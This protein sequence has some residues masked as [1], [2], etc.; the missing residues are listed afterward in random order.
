MYFNKPKKRLGS[1][2]ED[3]LHIKKH[4]FFNDIDW[5][6]LAK[7]ELVPP[8]IPDVKNPNDIKYISPEFTEEEVNQDTY[9]DRFLK[10]RI[11]NYEGFSFVPN[12]LKSNHSPLGNN[13]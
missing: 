6:K 8:F 9:D 7:L 10:G 13:V 1:D 12:T 5:I 2:N 4:P 3:A 11:E